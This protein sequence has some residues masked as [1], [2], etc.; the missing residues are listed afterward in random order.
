MCLEEEQGSET[1]SPEEH[2]SKLAA[3]CPQPTKSGAVGAFF[4]KDLIGAV[5]MAVLK[6]MALCLDNRVPVNSRGEKQRSMPVFWRGAAQAVA[7]WLS[8]SSLCV[9]AMLVCGC[10]F[11]LTQSAGHSTTPPSVTAHGAVV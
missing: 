9:G 3:G 2:W 1:S 6:N 8:P 7:D 5:C 11:Q 10:V 4:R